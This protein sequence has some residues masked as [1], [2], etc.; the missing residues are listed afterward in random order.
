[1]PDARQP[2]LVD[3]LRQ[4]GAEVIDA[5][6]VRP[7]WRR[8]LSRSACLTQLRIDCAL[9]SNS[10]A[11]SSGRRPTR[12]SSIILRRYFGAY[13]AWLLGVVALLHFPHSA[14]VHQTGSTPTFD[15]VLV[16]AVILAGEERFENH[17]SEQNQRLV[18]DTT[19]KLVKEL[20]DR[21]NKPI[22]RGRLRILGI[23]APGEV[24]SLGLLMLLELLRRT[25]SAA[26][27]LGTT[28]SPAEICAFVSQYA[29]DMVFL[30]CTTTECMPAA[31]ELVRFL[32]TESPHLTIIG[33]GASAL[34]H[35][36]ELLEAGAAQICGSRGEV[37]HV[38]GLYALRRSVSRSSKI[39]SDRSLI[40]TQTAISWLGRTPPP[41]YSR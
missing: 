34:L 1:M 5:T 27:F 12:T 14:S 8:P 3:V 36:S 31:V 17:I 33:G 19:V 37:R 10:F 22:V 25:G 29:P 23:A 16:P 6:L 32:M 18:F 7:S 2:R 30:S 39:S 41:T 35:R 11:N 15:D 38:V 13:C 40:D 20:G 28:K 4:D 21:F 9:G 26:N 24:H